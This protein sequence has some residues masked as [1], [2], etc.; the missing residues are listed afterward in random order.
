MKCFKSV[1]WALVAIWAHAWYC[2]VSGKA[3][4]KKIMNEVLNTPDI[5]T[6]IRLSVPVFYTVKHIYKN[7]I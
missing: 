3:R 1:G 7:A 6:V 4:Y 2:T 5:L